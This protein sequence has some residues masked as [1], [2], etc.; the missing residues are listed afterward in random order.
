MDGAGRR[1]D[2]RAGPHDRRAV[3]ARVLSSRSRERAAASKLLAGS[4]AERADGHRRQEEARRRRARGA[5][6]GEGL[7]LRAGHGLLRVGLARSA[8]WDL[9]LGELARIWK[10]GCIIRA[11]FLGRIKEAYD[12]RR[13]RSPNLLV[14]PSLPQA[15]SPSGRRAGARGRRTAV[16]AGI[17]LPDDGS[18]LATTTSLRRERLPREP[19]AGAARLLRRAHLRAHRQAGHVPYGV[20]REVS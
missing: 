18:A 13:Q 6:R 5:L 20:V 7:Q 17:P 11:Q 16:D 2:R 10:G 14:D 9:N 19:H 12:A 8:S 3:E 1:G 4:D 15:S